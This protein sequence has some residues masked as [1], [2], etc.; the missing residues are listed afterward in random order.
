M[1]YVCLHFIAFFCS[2]DLLICRNC[3]IFFS[4]LCCALVANTSN[5]TYSQQIGMPNKNQTVKWRRFVLLA[6]DTLCLVHKQRIYFY[7]KQFMVVIVRSPLRF[8]YLTNCLPFLCIFALMF[9]CV[10]ISLSV[11]LCV[12]SFIVWLFNFDF[13]CICMAITYYNRRIHMWQR[14]TQLNIAAKSAMHLWWLCYSHKFAYFL[15]SMIFYH[16][17]MILIVWF[18]QKMSCSIYTL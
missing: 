11:C 17:Q 12:H 15:L 1:L 5:N 13:M 18:F 4:C 2:Y 3:M 9:I 16:F 8:L 10:V 14:P 7:F 6:W